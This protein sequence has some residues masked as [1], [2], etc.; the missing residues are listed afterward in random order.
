PTLEPSEE[1]RGV[2]TDGRPYRAEEWPLARAIR[3][4]AVV[5]GAELDAVRGAGARATLLTRAPPLRDRDA[6]IIARAV[7]LY[8][9][10]ERERAAWR[11][12]GSGPTMIGPRVARGQP[13]GAVTFVA[14]ASGP[15]SAREDLPG[16]EERGR[17][18][19]LAVDN[20][21]LYREAR[22][23]DRI[24]GEFLMALSHE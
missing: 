2:H 20:S 7:P 14:A 10:T 12:R 8:A 4:G 22:E 9:V 18:A 11:H 24:K 19:A 5:A 21:R 3:A 6:G 17:R 16:A 13:R 1:H 15:R 23:A